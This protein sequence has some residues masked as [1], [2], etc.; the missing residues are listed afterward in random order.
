MQG[1]TLSIDVLKFQNMSLVGF[2]VFVINF[3]RLT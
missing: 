2:N 1:L 3:S